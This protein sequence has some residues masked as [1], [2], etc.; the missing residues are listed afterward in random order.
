MSLD[1][2]SFLLSKHAPNTAKT[3]MS[4]TLQDAVPIGSLDAR[5][6]KYTPPTNSESKSV[7]LVSRAY[8]LQ[9][10]SNAADKILGA[11]S[12]LEEE[13]TKEKRYWEQ[14]LSIKQKGWSVSKVPRDPRTLGVHFGFRDAAPS[15]RNRGFAALRRYT[16]GSLQLDQ[17]AIPS[18]PVAVQVSILSDGKCRG[19]SIIPQSSVANEDAI[20]EQILQARN[21]LYEE[22]LFQELG[23]ETRLLANQGAT[24]SSKR[25]KMPL[26]KQTQI[27]IDLINLDDDNSSDT[28]ESDQQ[29]ADG[30]AIA[31]RILLSHAHEQNLR[32]RCQPPPPMTLKP[33]PIPE[34]AL[35]R[36]I[37]THLQHLNNVS[38]LTT[39][40]KT[41]TQP[42]Q[43]AGIPCSLEPRNPLNP[44]DSTTLL[45]HPLADPHTL[46]QNFLLDPTK[47]TTTTLTFHLPTTRPLTLTIHTNISPPHFGTDFSFSP[48]T[49]TYP[50]SS[51]SATLPRLRSFDEVVSVLKQI[52][53]LD[54]VAYIASERAQTSSLKAEN[55]AKNDD[56]KIKLGEEER[57]TPLSPHQGSLSRGTQR[58]YIKIWN[59]RLGVRYLRSTKRGDVAACV[60][61]GR[62][63]MEVGA[64]TAD[65]KRRKGEGRRLVDVVLD[66]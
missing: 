30:I 35:I 58:L 65:G 19:T 50:S 36:P 44:L 14:I 34:Y 37:I 29:L 51:T 23:R 25:I 20:D 53:T 13:A 40:L 3:T 24:I 17:G 31:L 7:D 43:H 33:R 46:L 47:S 12:R 27:Q 32:R 49:L 56:D 15:F 39:F 41:L 10:F 66:R 57:W 28:S 62:G 8:K 6:M 61:D 26:D 55:A 18:R 16:D 5:V 38:S 2:I 21:T 11:A 45:P 22:E 42:F 1:F 59:D 64:A 48:A 4:P 9:G 52:L 63:E 60:W 54:L